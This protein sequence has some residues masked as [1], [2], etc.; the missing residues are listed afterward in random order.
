MAGPSAASGSA[1][2]PST[3]RRVSSNGI[4]PNI[5]S[6]VFVA[7]PEDVGGKNNDMLDDVAEG[8][9]E[10]EEGEFEDEE[11]PEWARRD[12]FKD[13]AL[14]ETVTIRSS[15]RRSANPRLSPSS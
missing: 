1:G 11:L 9:E 12:R 10:E 7:E 15:S 5:L 6:D 4:L 8:D 2:G 3:L 13:D 14:G